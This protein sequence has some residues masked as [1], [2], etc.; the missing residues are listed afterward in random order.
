[1][2]NYQTL[3]ATYYDWVNNPEP[4][5]PEPDSQTIL[6]TN[7]YGQAWLYNTQQESTEWLTYHGETK[8]L[9]R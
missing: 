5:L 4:S 1:M 2:S 9:R 6:D 7:I 3:E 8:D